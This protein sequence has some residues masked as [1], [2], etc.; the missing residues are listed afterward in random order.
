MPIPAS[1]RHTLVALAGALV[2]SA[3]AGAQEQSRNPAESL[4]DFVHYTQIAKPELAAANAAA[5]IDSGITDAE[6]AELVDEGRVSRDR[7]DAALSRAHRIPELEDIAAELDR[8]VLTGRLDLARDQKRIEEAIAMLTGTLRMKM[9]AKRLLAAA[10]EYAVPALLRVITEGGNENLR[11]QAEEMIIMIGRHAVT[12]LCAAL[13]ELD[14][15]NQRRVCSMLGEIG[16][17]HAG[18]ALME[19]A[20]NEAAPATTTNAAARAFRRVGGVNGDLSLLYTRLGRQYFNESE[21]LIAYPFES[22]NNVWSYDPFSGLGATPVATEIFSEVMAMH[23]ASKALHIDPGNA[24]ALS[25]FVAANLRRS[26]ELPPGAVDPIYGENPYSPEFYAMVFGTQVCLDV[27]AMGIDRLDTPLV[28]DAIAALS[29]TTGG[30]NLF[31][32]SGGRQPLLDALRYPDRRVQYEAALTLGEALPRQRFPGDVRVVPLL[33]SAVRTGDESFAVVI[34]DS[35]EDRRVHA[36]RLENL[37]FTIVAAGEGLAEVRPE[38]A[39]AVGVDLVV[40]QVASA[41]EAVDTVGE[42]HVEP[43]TAAAPILIVAPAVD[44]ARLKRDFRDEIRVKVARARVNADAYGA[45]VDEVML[46]AAGGRM[47]E[48]E[49]EAYAIDAI[50]TLRDIAIS[51]STAYTIID[52]ESA[53]VQALAARRGALRLSVADILALIDSDRAQR[54]LFDAALAASDEEQIDLLDRVAESVKRFGDRTEPRHVEG[55]LNLITSS[56]GY[57]AEA[58]ARVHG[59]L[60]LPSGTAI[61]LIP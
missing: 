47:M 41:Q 40:L 33:A 9:L 37:G 29:Q 25:L 35:E 42:L 19:L 8:R 45:S 54:V 48:A 31:T 21:S 1:F 56:G 7:F 26:N 30:A 52:A 50:M 5:L 39:H 49:A 32:A 15:A 34:A 12:P 58:A 44:L 55:L 53:L 3:P 23:A 17:P 60:V 28:H 22:T 27:L 13:P 6:L 18:P 51:G 43:Q 11:S 14:P 10:G 46:R 2:L 59:A 4:A 24:A 38:V 20:V 16:H 61:E 36:T 57:T